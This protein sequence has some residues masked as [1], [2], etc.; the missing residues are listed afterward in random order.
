MK[1]KYII[2]LSLLLSIIYSNNLKTE[3][4]QQDKLLEN[5]FRHTYANPFE[6]I[7]FTAEGLNY[8]FE[9]IYN[10]TW[11]GQDF[12][13]NNFTHMIQFLKFGK[14]NNQKLEF[15]KSVIK[16]FG[17]KIKSTTY[18][19]PYAL[20]EL[21]EQ[22]PKLI[23]HYFI[24]PEANIFENNKKLITDLLFSSFRSQFSFFKKSPNKFL[25]NLSVGIL[26]ALN[27]Q[28]GLIDKR[29]T[30]ENIRQSLI[31]MLE[32]YIGKL[33]WDPK[34]HKKIWK[35]FYA[36]NKNVEKLAEKNIITD[37]DSLDD[38]F[39][40]LIHRFCF[41]IE[42][43][44]QDLPINFYKKFRNKIAASDLFMFEIA[45]QEQTIKT[46]ESHLMHALFEGE[47]KARAYKTGI[48]LRG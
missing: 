11:Y 21:L 39:W 38:L 4:F 1:I 18:V 47:A 41:F 33:V 26:E 16:L 2:S 12:L 37:L 5:E 8:F 10:Q 36:I 32:L 44:A 34:E 31:R 20:I 30:I 45:E 23:K 13:P 28:S 42:L 9:S 7:S 27:K 40:S 46:K 35:L 19:N 15:F 48:V 6:P 22:M 24:I 17:N 29:V 25:N 14:K 3:N 43:A